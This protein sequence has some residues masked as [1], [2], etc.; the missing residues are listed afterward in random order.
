MNT[1]DSVLACNY[2]ETSSLEVSPEEKVQEEIRPH[3]TWHVK[4][5]ST[6]YQKATTE[7]YNTG[8][9]IGKN[10]GFGDKRLK[11]VTVMEIMMTIL[12]W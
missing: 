5:Q 7:K 8:I 4:A 9:N 11:M 1:L 12:T 6:G 2:P 10:K 3:Q